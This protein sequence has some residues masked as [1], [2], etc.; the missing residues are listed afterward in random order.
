[1]GQLDR[2]HSNTEASLTTVTTM[3][4]ALHIFKCTLCKITFSTLNGALSCFLKF[5]CLTLASVTLWI[6]EL[7]S[8]QS[9]K[10]FS[11]SDFNVLKVWHLCDHVWKGWTDFYHPLTRRFMSNP[12]LCSIEMAFMVMKWSPASE[13]NCYTKVLSSNHFSKRVLDISRKFGRVTLWW[14]D[15][16]LKLIT[17]LWSLVL[18]WIQPRKLVSK[19][20]LIDII[21]RNYLFLLLVKFGRKIWKSENPS[22]NPISSA[23]SLFSVGSR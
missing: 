7:S 14:S 17:K 8:S 11:L 15:L 2:F 23:E 10:S 19:I 12:L 16:P 13:K 6:F 4:V 18:K 1:M 3:A 5:V 9:L 21:R 20:K 22:L